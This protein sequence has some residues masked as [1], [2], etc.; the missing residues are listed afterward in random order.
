MLIE[1]VKRWTIIILMIAV[2]LLALVIMAQ[3]IDVQSAHNRVTA[4]EQSNQVL[5]DAAKNNA[6]Q[7]KAMATEANANDA[8]DRGKQKAKASAS[9]RARSNTYAVHKALS[10]ESCATVRMPDGTISMLRSSGGNKDQ[11]ILSNSASRAD[12]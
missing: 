9:E 10:T 8:L 4:L 6:D 2:A 7:V 12:P 5:F 11:N 3:R 1:S